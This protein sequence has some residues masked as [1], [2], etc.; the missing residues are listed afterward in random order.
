MNIMVTR[1]QPPEAFHQGCRA[2]PRL[3]V[4]PQLEDRGE[5]TALPQVYSATQYL[6]RRRSRSDRPYRS[7]EHPSCQTEY[8]FHRKGRD[9]PLVVKRV[10]ILV[11]NSRYFRGKII[12]CPHAM[13]HREDSSL[14]RQRVILVLAGAIV[15]VKRRR[16]IAILLGNSFHPA[17]RFAATCVFLD[18]YL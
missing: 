15:A 2:V 5:R 14:L 11:L 7:V 1:Y 18:H 16:S 9:P 17:A 3:R 6:L 10:T 13:R 8:R 12:S 4:L